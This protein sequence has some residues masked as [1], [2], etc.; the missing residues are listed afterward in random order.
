MPVGYSSTLSSK[1]EGLAGY[2][3]VLELVKVVN[4]S[5]IHKFLG[6]GLDLD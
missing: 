5:D 1:H 6:G 4:L 2:D 3:R